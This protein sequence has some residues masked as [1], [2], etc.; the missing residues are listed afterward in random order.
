M[1]EYDFILKS[2]GFGVDTME[3]RTKLAMKFSNIRKNVGGAHCD[4]DPLYMADYLLSNQNLSGP[5]IEFGCYEGGM[6]CKLS[7]VCKLL[8][9]S[10]VIFDTFSG[11]PANAEYETYDKDFSHLGRFFKDSFGCSI[12]KVK[13]NIENFGD[14]SV[15]SFHVGL[16][17]DT[18]PL[19][20][21]NPSCIFIDVD[22]IPTAKFIIK[23]IY[24]NVEG[25]KIFTHEGCVKEYMEAIL[26]KE[27]WLS[28]MNM[29][30]PEAGLNSITG[31]P[32]LDGSMCITYLLNKN[33]L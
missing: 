33:L 20:S 6:S 32:N 29:E 24:R 27:W 21:Y 26:E 31:L 28:E 13:S 8:N 4:P 10:Y 17:E 9:K 11:I 30:P 15:C 3:N 14:I 22:L 23:N 5:F 1:T 7:L 2:T 25:D 16:I 18:L 12:D 19:T